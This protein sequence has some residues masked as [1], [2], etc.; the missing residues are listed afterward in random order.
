LQHQ[1]TNACIQPSIHPPTI[2]PM[3]L[4]PIVNTWPPIISASKLYYSVLSAASCHTTQVWQHTVLQ[5]SSHLNP[6]SPHQSTASK[7]SFSSFFG[8]MVEKGSLYMSSPLQPLESIH[9]ILSVSTSYNITEC[10]H[11]YATINSRTPGNVCAISNILGMALTSTC[12][13]NFV[14]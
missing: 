11:H 6:G 14:D 4:Q 9:A 7:L 3:A 5:P 12:S 8:H 13:L 1:K 10:H 2:N